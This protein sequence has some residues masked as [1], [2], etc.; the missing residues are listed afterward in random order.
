MTLS[1][2]SRRSAFAVLAAL[3]AV[4]GARSAQAAPGTLDNYTAAYRVA[5]EVHKP[6]LVVL[7]GDT[8]SKEVDVEELSSD[9]QLASAMGDY[10]VAEIDTTTK[11]GQKVLKLFN[12]PTLPHLVV[13]DD[14]Q[15]K[16]LFKT[17]RAL[18]APELAKVLNDYK[19]GPPST[20]QVVSAAKPSV[21]TT[22]SPVVSSPTTYS[23]PIQSAPVRS[24]PVQAAPVYSSPASPVPAVS[25]PSFSSGL[26]QAIPPNCPSCKL[27]AMGLIP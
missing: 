7:N 16:Q 3:V 10:V 9:N 6:M 26:P 18:S 23:A 21:N 24:A 14:A 20:P 2:H 19:D 22:S 25:L 11:H 1:L 17:S 12:S 8:Q 27:K 15:K 4:T 13:I 5:G